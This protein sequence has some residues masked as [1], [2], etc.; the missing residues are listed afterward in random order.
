MLRVLRRRHLQWWLWLAPLIA[1]GAV[2]GLMARPPQPIQ[3]NPFSEAASRP[4]DAPAESA[5]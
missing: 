4:V 3:T 1:V 2:M 5:P